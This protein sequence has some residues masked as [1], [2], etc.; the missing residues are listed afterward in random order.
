MVH[1]GSKFFVVSRRFLWGFLNVFQDLPGILCK[2]E[3]CPLVA[4][5]ACQ[6][7]LEAHHAKGTQLMGLLTN[8]WVYW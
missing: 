2:E 4:K 5:V 1:G 8:T 7:F 3:T 6:D